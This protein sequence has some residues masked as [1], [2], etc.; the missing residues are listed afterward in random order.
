VSSWALH[1]NWL[2]GL[3][4]DLRYDELSKLKLE[5][6]SIGEHIGITLLLRTKNSLNFKDYEF[7]DWSKT[8]LASCHG[9]DPTLASCLWLKHRG[10]GNGY[11]FCRIAN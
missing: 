3:H 5:G 10:D 1:A 8:E 7:T 2:I 4:C 6:T 11:F 9:M